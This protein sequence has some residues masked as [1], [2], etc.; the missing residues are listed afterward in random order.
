MNI[1]TEVGLCN[2]ALGTLAHFVYPNEQQPPCLPI[3]VIIQFDEN[4]NGP[5]ISSSFARSVQICPITQVSQ[6]LGH[7]ADRQQLPLRLAWAMTIHK[8]QGLTLKKAWVDLGKSENIK[9]MTYVA[10]SRV[11]N[12]SD[13]VVEPMT[14]ERLQ[15]P[16]KSPNLHSRIMD[17]Q[18]LNKISQ[19]TV[20][21]FISNNKVV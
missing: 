21:T 6:T 8:S 14:L 19:T 4:C 18:Q 17:E 2:G 7:S 10:L 16:K 3:C 9:G 11:R 1:W 5:S 20:S 13:L 15:A 12:L